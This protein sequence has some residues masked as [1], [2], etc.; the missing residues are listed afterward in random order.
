V[1]R[2]VSPNLVI[3]DHDALRERTFLAAVA[4]AV[5]RA[6]PEQ[7]VQLSDEM[8][9]AATVATQTVTEARESGTLI[10][11][12]E[13]DEVNQRVI[14]RQLEL[15]GFAAEIAADGVEALQLWRRGGCGLLITDLHMP[16]MDGYQLAAAIRAEELPGERVPIVALTANA[17]RG[18][19]IRARAAGM[20]GY[21]TKPIRLVDLKREI[22]TR[23][24]GELPSARAAA[25][26]PAS[27]DPASVEPIVEGPSGPRRLSPPVNPAGPALDVSVLQ[28]F[29]GDDAELIEEFLREYR[30]S[31]ELHMAALKA[32]VKSGDLAQAGMSAH[33][34]KLS[35]RAAGATRL[36]DLL[37]E[38]ES[39]AKRHD[40]PSVAAL[41]DTTL[42]EFARVE[43]ALDD[44]VPAA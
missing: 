30:R 11:V 28:N 43:Q 2:V 17:L 31:A 44:R 27:A 34:L 38:V 23:M 36:G 15:L 42:A 24:N 7:P 8:L 21:L 6:S 10:L 33:T 39:A 37:A 26:D 32:A 25:V 40:A 9:V 22:H 12:A 19:E 1:P 13:D 41:L 5:G 14:L 4:V 20:D 29:V 35:S 16:K 3:L 18:E